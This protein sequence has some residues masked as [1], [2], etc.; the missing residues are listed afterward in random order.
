MNSALSIGI[1]G[2]ALPVTMLLILNTVY[3]ESGPDPAKW[4]LSVPGFKKVF[5]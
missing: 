2:F 1:Y 4:V 5:K 3:L